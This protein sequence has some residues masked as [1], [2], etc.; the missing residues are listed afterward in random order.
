MNVTN[1]NF[2][3]VYPKIKKSLESATFVAIDAEFSGLQS[4]DKNISYLNESLFDSPKERYTKLR[5]NIEPFI[6][7]QFGL[8]AF[9]YVKHENKYNAESFEFYLIPRPLPTKNRTFLV[10][11]VTLQF[12]TFYKFDFNELVYNAVSYLDE[13][14]ETALRRSL[15]DY[16]YA[17]EA[18]ESGADEGRN[19]IEDCFNRVQ[20]WLKSESE[21]LS[22]EAPDF[23]VSYKTQKELRASF[24]TIW[25]ECSGPN[26]FSVIKVSPEVRESLEKKNVPDKLNKK[27]LDYYI[28]FSKVFKLISSLKKPIVGH[29]LFLDLMFMHK[30]FYLPLPENYE[31]FKKNV[32]RLF[33]LV[34]DT[35]FL[36]FEMKKILGETSWKSNVLAELYNYYKDGQGRY[37]AM[38]SPSIVLSSDSAIDSDK[39]RGKFHNAA[40]DS[41]C[42]GYCFI[43]MAHICAVRKQSKDADMRI[44][45]NAEIMS[46]VMERANRINL[47]RADLSHLVIIDRAAGW[48]GSCVDET[49][50]AVGTSLDQ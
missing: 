15:E 11:A 28:G 26:N 16:S 1:T 45:T 50:V 25:T 13:N 49:P 22:I 38:N 12:H 7:I 14:E 40:W 30:Q 18:S 42:T 39:C 20:Q 47:I 35:K 10:Q 8:T 21:A 29:N 48:S 46:G 41:Y 5:K 33:P 6:A 31:T 44:L 3:E 27:L 24:K 43:R 19:Q 9:T 23:V 34:Y 2:E 37:L 36:S 32:N 17:W 4:A